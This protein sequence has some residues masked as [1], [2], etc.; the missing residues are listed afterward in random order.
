MKKAMACLLIAALLLSLWG[1]GGIEDT[2]GGIIN[3]LTERANEEAGAETGGEDRTESSG[4]IAAAREAYEALSNEDKTIFYEEIAAEQEATRQARLAE[5][6]SGLSGE[7]CM[8][9]PLYGGYGS[10]YADGI[11]LND[12]MTYKYGSQKGTWYFDEEEELIWFMNDADGVHYFSFRIIEEDGFVKLLNLEGE[13]CYVRKENYRDILDQKYVIVLR[14]MAPEY[15]GEPQYVG[16]QEQDVGYGS[17]TPLAIMDS[18]AYENGLI[19]VGHTSPF[20]M[21]VVQELKNGATVTHSL[22]SPFA[23]MK[24]YEGA[25][26]V[27]IRI[28]S[29]MVYF[30][31]AEYVEEV[32]I[33]E[34]S[35]RKVLMKT[36]D[37]F[38]DYTSVWDDF[39]EIS[40]DEFGY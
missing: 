20:E 38:Y 27:S 35:N 33:D 10:V 30:V 22:W 7:W 2:V 25:K 39:P 28:E 9:N 37:V 8:E 26:T 3:D 12:D 40:Y 15:F 17:N 19:Y 18:L 1:C 34:E 14:A 29:G 16:I 11:L 21:E 6:L 5:L 36:G 24:Y 32:V 23:Y 4:D 13:H 31:R